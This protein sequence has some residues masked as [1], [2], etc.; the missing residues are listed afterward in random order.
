MERMREMIRATLL[1]PHVSCQKKGLCDETTQL[2]SL[3]LS[4]SMQHRRIH[5]RIKTHIRKMHFA[6]PAASFQLEHSNFS[7]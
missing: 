6:C 4:A 1:F 7:L 2:L 3:K 5:K